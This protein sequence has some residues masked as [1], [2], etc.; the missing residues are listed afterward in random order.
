MV[1]KMVSFKKRFI[2]T[3][4]ALKAA[5][6]EKRLTDVTRESFLKA[7]GRPSLRYPITARHVAYRDEGTGYILIAS[8]SIYVVNELTIKL[9]WLCDG[10]H[11]IREIILTLS[12]EYKINF[13]NARQ[14]VEE[15]L[16]KGSKKGLIYW[17]PLSPLH[18]NGR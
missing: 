10:F 9:L 1:I 8:D 14:I 6:L 17:I 18:K 4:N 12:K 11:S 16:E 5:H 13:E 7:Y 2:N 15:F 3:F